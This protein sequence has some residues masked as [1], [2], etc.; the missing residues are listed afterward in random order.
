MNNIDRNACALD[1]ANAKYSG[2]NASGILLSHYLDYSVL[3]ELQHHICRSCACYANVAPNSRY[4]NA[5]P[6]YSNC[7]DPRYDGFSYRN[8]G[9]DA[10]LLNMI[11]ADV[12]RLLGSDVGVGKQTPPCILI[13]AAGLTMQEKTRPCKRALRKYVGFEPIL[14]FWHR[15]TQ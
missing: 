10:R 2:G 5:L 6:A 13:P 8:Y 1:S 15:I 11:P 14:L 4:C 9:F 3:I 12:A 7:F